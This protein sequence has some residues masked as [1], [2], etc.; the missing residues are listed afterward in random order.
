MPAHGVPA[1]GDAR[2]IHGRRG[3]RLRRVPCAVGQYAHRRGA[4]Q[5][6]AATHDQLGDDPMTEST[7]PKKRGGARPGAGRPCK[8]IEVPADPD[9]LDYLQLLMTSKN[10]PE[11][12]RL[13]A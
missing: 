4:G 5:A 6:G 1:R 3:A 12:L 2:S 9:P 11:P 8:A 7:A 10:T 13:K